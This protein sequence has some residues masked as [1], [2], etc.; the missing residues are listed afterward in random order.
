VSKNGNFLLD[1]GPQPNGT[2]IDVEQRALREAGRWLKSHGEAIYN[3]TYWFVTPEE[4]NV[5]F[6]TT[7]DAFYICSFVKPGNT[8]VLNSPIPSVKTDNVTVVGGGVHGEVIPAKMLENGSLELTVGH[9]VAQDMY[10]WVFKIT[11]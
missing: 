10:T 9:V 6:T 4:G 8:I 5:R 11:Y 1:V 3:T 2:I 7:N